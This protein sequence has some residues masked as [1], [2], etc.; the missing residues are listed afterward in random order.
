MALFLP[1]FLT[2]VGLFLVVGVYEELF[3]RGYLLTNVAEGLVG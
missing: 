3:A 2:G 1:E